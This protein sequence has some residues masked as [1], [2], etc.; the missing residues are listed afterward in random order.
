MQG[1][2]TVIADEIEAKG[3]IGFDRF[4]ELALYHP[5]DGFYASG[6]RAGRRGDFLTSP[7]VGPLF[8][9]V[10]ARAI[11]RWWDELGRPEPWVVVDAGAGPGTLAASVLAAEPACAGALRYVLVERSGPQRARHG[12]HLDLT[13]PAYVFMGGAEPDDDPAELPPGPQVVSL[14]ELPRVT[15]TGVVVANE[16]LDNLPTRL[17]QRRADGWDVVLVGTSQLSDGFVE[18]LVP[19]S[20]E[21]AELA[22]R[23][24]PATAPGARLPIQERASAWLRDV[25]AMLERGRIMVFDYGDR[26]ASLSQRPPDEW[27]R[28]YRAHEPGLPP[29]DAAGSQDI[30][31]EVA[32]DQLDRVRSATTTR[33]QAEFLAEHGI[34]ELVE[35]GRQRWEERAAIGDLEALAARSRVRE[36]EALVDQEG[37]GAFVALEWA[38]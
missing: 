8:G 29:L 26:S 11:D 7:E 31:C 27:L 15:V 4:M 36:A 5:E 37:L 10:L 18:V 19:A 25:L 6:G 33:T 28:T 20:A 14:A 9:A 32:F 35:T 17:V 23:L 13:P 30:T 3:P 22:D 1:A 12:E 34:E 38:I 24:A 2:A 21:L 16:L